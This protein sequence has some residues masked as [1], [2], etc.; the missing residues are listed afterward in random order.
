[1]KPRYKSIRATNATAGATLVT[2]I[3]CCFAPAAFGVQNSWIGTTTD[4]NTPGNWS[5]G[6]VPKNPNG[7]SSGDTF[8]DAVVNTLTNTPVLGANAGGNPRD[9]VVGGTGG[10][11]GRIDHTAGTISS[12]GWLYIGQNGGNGTYNAA[13]TA[14]TGGSFTSFGL[15]GASLTSTGRLL[16]GTGAGSTGAFNLNT[17]GTFTVNGTGYIGDN[18]GTGTV[19][20]D[21]GTLNFNGEFRLGQ[22]NGTHGTARLSGGTISS[23]NWIGIGASG[24]GQGALVIS[25]GTFNKTSGGAFII[26][27]GSST[28]TI[29]QTGGNLNTTDFAIGRGATS[30]ASY[31]ISGGTA[32]MTAAFSI[33][34]GGSVASLT[35]SGGSVTKKVGAGDLT[36][37]DGAAAGVTTALTVNGG[38]LDVQTGSLR[39]GTSG[40]GNSNLTLSSG[41][42]RTPQLQAGQGGNSISTV[43]LTGGTL[44]TA[45]IAG[46]GATE[47]FTFDGTQI[48]ASATSSSFIAN[49]DTAVIGSANGG[50]KINSNG[51]SLVSN[52]GFSGAGGLTKSGS[53]TLT[54]GGA[55]AYQGPT[56]VSAGKLVTSTNSTGGGSVTVADGA[57]LGVVTA[58]DNGQQTVSTASFATT[59]TGAKLEFNL[60]NFFDNATAAPL[61][62]TGN[63]VV[64]G[65]VTINVTDQLPATGTIPLIQYGTRSGAGSFV[66]GTLPLGVA[67]TLDTSV[68]GLVSLN[69]TSV[70]LPLWSGSNGSDWTTADN[71]VDQVTFTTVSF[72]N[73]GPALFD[74]S[75]ALFDIVISKA[76]VWPSLVTFAN[77]VF[78]YTVTGTKKITGSG[79][80]L[81]KGAGEVVLDTLNDYTG[82]TTLSGGITSAGVLSNGGAASSIGAA[83]ASPDNLILAGGT[84]HYTGPATTTNRGFTNLAANNQTTSTIRTENDLTIS[85]GIVS[86]F[87]ALEKTGPGTLS[88]TNAG[89]LNISAAGFRV[90]EGAAVLGSGVSSAAYGSGG[91]LAV[92]PG[93]G[94]TLANLTNLTTTGNN[95]IGDGS[96]D[97]GTLT[98][99]G[100]ATLTASGWLLAGTAPGSSGTILLN[101]SSSVT[102]TALVSVGQGGSGTLTVKNS[103]QFNC[104]A[105]NLNIGDLANSTG[106]INISDTAHITA[107]STFIGKAIGSSGSANISGGTLDI[108]ST[109]VGSDAGSTGGVNMTGGMA[110]I[111]TDGG[112]HLMG[113]HGTGN[114]LQSAG[115]VNSRG[116]MVVGRYADGGASNLTVT[117]GTFN[118][119]TVGRNLTIGE[120]CAGTVTVSGTGTVNVAGDEGVYVSKSATGAGTINLNTGGTLITSRVTAGAGGAG[121]STIN[122]DGGTLRARPSGVSAVFMDLQDTA[123]VKAGGA[124]ID[125][126]GQNLVINQDFTNDGSTGNLVKTGAGTLFLNGNVN[127]KG[128]VH[129]S[130]GTIGGTGT[131]VC[132]LSVEGTSNLN[133]GGAAPG[134]L[135]AS[136][137]TFSSTSSLTVDLAATAD[138][139]VSG[140]LTLNGAALVLNGTADQPVYVIARYTSLT[141]QF[142]GGANPPGLPSGYSINY[143]YD[144]GTSIALVAGSGTP[145]QAWEAARITAIN[146]GAD[147][148]PGGNPDNDGLNNLAE[149]AL[150]ENPLSGASSGKMV[151]KVASV[152]GVPSLVLTLPVRTVATFSGATEQVSGLVSGLIYRIQGSGTLTSWNLAVSEVTALAD[153]SSIE[154]GFPVLESGWSYRTFTTGPVSG[155]SKKFIRTIIE[156]P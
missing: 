134:T 153:K 64:N 29:T 8:D 127:L 120:E 42:I 85:G 114:W 136:S 63:M 113:S 3:I 156:Q 149:F 56:V 146:P 148:T 132:P 155:N 115:T 13:N 99:N 10:T 57:T 108:G 96:G 53:G 55:L 12:S 34:T 72:A 79:G 107:G 93:A 150:D 138:Q 36:V 26:G 67:A 77:D 14:A 130:S 137:T 103:A 62:V 50:L 97:P 41:E 24:T 80:L 38:I 100:G 82:V 145:Y 91:T 6:R 18:G 40:S 7:A 30:T 43:N 92:G 144:G 90:G 135:T 75:A 39:L 133:P 110:N 2:T 9:I 1:M 46:G 126:N 117:G 116:W 131:I 19:N 95:S 84:L 106:V 94:L 140:P 74:D 73:N 101:D 154:A 104:G 52:Q 118:Q 15:G 143:A 32:V 54:L 151:S 121:S 102:T 37:G 22:G 45:A 33:G 16:V 125:S 81:K 122:F 44:T 109:Y 11:T 65:P 83:P 61:N 152:G 147:A 119:A 5:L 28:G 111:S 142:A 139:L 123:L 141:G 78:P 20:V 71:W 70:S 51:F 68:A 31:T 35:I 98:L 59:P 4:W 88:L 69:V 47:N 87:G 128:S 49:L 66:L 105:N 25:G 76:N 21:G 124:N 58:V 23:N 27:D 112:E 48:V 129:V 86:T 60:G 17:S 89:P